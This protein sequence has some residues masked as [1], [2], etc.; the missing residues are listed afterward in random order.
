MH[1]WWPCRQGFVGDSLVCPYK[2]FNQSHLGMSLE[3]GHL[4]AW[5]TLILFMLVG[6]KIW[7]SLVSLSLW[8][9]S[10]WVLLWPQSNAVWSWLATSKFCTNHPMGWMRNYYVGSWPMCLW[11]LAGRDVVQWT[12]SS[13][14]TLP[15]IDQSRDWRWNRLVP[16]CNNAALTCPITH[17]HPRLSYIL[18]SENTHFLCQYDT[19]L[20]SRWIWL[21][22]G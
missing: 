10:F 20:P 8:T 12:Q 6:R 2:I 14:R 21:D 17:T 15:D 16:S 19:V 3:T 4:G 11:L 5:L 7:C 18:I 13:W 1:F 22:T 9:C